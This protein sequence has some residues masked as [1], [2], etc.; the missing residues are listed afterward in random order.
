MVADGVDHVVVAE[1]VGGV[2]CGEDRDRDGTGREGDGEA[3]ELTGEGGGEV[4]FGMAAEGVEVSG[5][6]GA[7]GEDAEGRKRGGEDGGDVGEEVGRAEGVAAAR[8]VGAVTV[9][10]TRGVDEVDGGEGLE[11]D[12]CAVD[13]L[14]E[15]SGGADEGKAGA[16][17]LQALE[18]VFAIFGGAHLVAALG[19]QLGRVVLRNHG[20]DRLVARVEEVRRQHDLPHAERDDEG[21]QLD[22]GHEQA[23]DQAE[24]G[25]D[26]DAAGDRG[27][28]GRSAAVHHPVSPSDHRAP[29][30]DRPGRLAERQIIGVVGYRVSVATWPV[31]TRPSALILRPGRVDLGRWADRPG[32]P[33]RP[34]VPGHGPIHQRANAR[35]TRL[36]VGPCEIRQY[37]T[38]D[39][40][41]LRQ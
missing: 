28:R 37:Q 3:R 17:F 26:G 36:A 31:G 33:P 5:R 23:V 7:E 24:Q 18:R 35:P 40:A 27:G 14:D 8:G 4:D 10:T 9:E 12:A 16:V 2:E 21:R 20:T 13:G 34:R 25:R 32:E 41:R 1:D 39:Y 11:V 6:F 29:S 30:K 19:Q 15:A 22:L 38:P